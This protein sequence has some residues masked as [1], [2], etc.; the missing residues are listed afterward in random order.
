MEEDNQE[1]DTCQHMFERGSNKGNKCTKP[2]Y[3]HLFCYDHGKLAIHKDEMERYQN[4]F[5]KQCEEHRKK[6]KERIQKQ[7]DE[8]KNNG[9]KINILTFNSQSDLDVSFD[10]NE[11]DIIKFVDGFLSCLVY[12]NSCYLIFSIRQTQLVNFTLDEIKKELELRGFNVEK[13]SS[14]INVDGRLN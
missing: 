12:F 7:I 6:V 1:S 3:H 9:R 14:C 8:A 13:L 4:N 10:K 2:K 11:K 5:N